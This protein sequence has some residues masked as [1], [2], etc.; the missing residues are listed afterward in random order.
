[1]EAERVKYFIKDAVE[2]WGVR[3]VMLVGGRNGGLLEE[4]WWCPVRYSHLDDNS[5]FE[6]SYLSDLYFGD[7]YKYDGEDIV[8]ADW[9]SNGN[10]V[11][12]EWRM[13]SKDILDLYP[14]VY[15]GRLACRNSYEVEVMVDKI[16]TYETTA[17]G[18]SWFNTFVG[19]GG[20]TYPSED[21]PY[22]EGELATQAAFD[23]LEGFEFVPLWTSNG[24]LT[25]PQ[26]V[27]DAVSRGCGFLH[28]SG[29]GNP[30][31]WSNHPPHDEET[32]IDGLGVGDMRKLSNDGMYPVCIVGGCHN[33]QFN[34]SLL[35]LLKIYEGFEQW[36]HYIWYGEMSPE[37]W[38]WWL[39]RKT[40]GGS[41]ATI[42]NTGLGYGQPGESCLERRGRYMELMFFRSY[43][44]GK[45]VLGETHGSD[46]TYYLHK[47]PPMEDRIDCKIVQQ[48]ALLGDPSLQIG[49]Y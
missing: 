7:L 5:N 20:D 17:A 21:D 23:Y 13:M 27:I 38:G 46:L 26:D 3:Y 24:E 16:I 14:D 6:S 30:M 22:Y 8:F 45:T 4:K 12:A 18:Q 11:F 9:D 49:G 48:W 36:K 19:V 25:G 33:N 28:F 47:F 29:H 32:W 15:V 40:G 34:V 1:D 44:E 37:S 42:A 31:A 41:I 2:E 43:A 10:G 35:N 39:A